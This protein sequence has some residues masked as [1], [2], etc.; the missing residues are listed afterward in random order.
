MDINDVINTTKGLTNRIEICV[1]NN[2]NTYNFF[3]EPNPP[4]CVEYPKLPPLYPTINGFK[5]N[6]MC[7]QEQ[8]QVDP[9]HYEII[10]HERYTQVKE[11]LGYMGINDKTHQLFRV[12]PKDIETNI[13]K[14]SCGESKP[15]EI[16]KG[17]Y[18]ADTGSGG[19][20]KTTE[21]PIIGSGSYEPIYQTA[22]SID[23]GILEWDISV[24]NN[25]NYKIKLKFADFYNVGDGADIYIN[26]RIRE[27]DINPGAIVG[28][29]TRL[30]KNYKVPVS[31]N[32][33]NIK[34]CNRA[35]LNAIDVYRLDKG[36]IKFADI[37]RDDIINN[38][39][40]YLF[41]NKNIEA[42]ED[43]IKN[44]FLSIQSTILRSR[45]LFFF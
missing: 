35:I 41:V 6:G 30:D 10:E 43:T 18:Q 12:D 44:K 24:K 14:I 5:E 42:S 9:N 39:E 21:I 1:I 45:N 26:N 22:R 15:I 34:L 37:T 25:T 23:D 17:V 32:H 36:D 28:Q 31:D 16:D 29:Y 27:K 8:S 2:L 11:L 19:I 20:I 4:K 3:I 13:V 7:N 33:I 40:I 38:K